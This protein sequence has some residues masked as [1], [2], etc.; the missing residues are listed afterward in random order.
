MLCKKPCL[1][2][3]RAMTREE[4]RRN[5]HSGEGTKRVHMRRMYAVLGKAA[6]STN[7]NA[8]MVN[9]E[10]YR[11]YIRVQNPVSEGITA[12]YED[13]K[14]YLEGVEHD[15]RIYEREKNMENV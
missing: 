11:P 2:E 8:I 4:K 1:C 12:A 10:K 13:M 14:A 6:L 9:L 7:D 15:L 3:P 5:K